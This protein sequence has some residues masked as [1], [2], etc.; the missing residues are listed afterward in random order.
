MA[1][2]VPVKSFKRTEQLQRHYHNHLNV[3]LYKC[4]SC[5]KRFKVGVKIRDPGNSKIRDSGLGPG[6]QF[7]GRGILGLNYSGRSRGLK[8][9][10]DTV[11]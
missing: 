1:F 11:P 7:V 6:L 9:F 3:R 2:N 10:Q 8:I 5:D 4:F